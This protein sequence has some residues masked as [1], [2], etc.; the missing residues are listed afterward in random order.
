MAFVIKNFVILRILQYNRTSPRIKSFLLKRNG[1]LVYWCQ[2]N[3]EGLSYDV[4]FWPGHNQEPPEP[5]WRYKGY[6]LL[7]FNINCMFNKCSCKTS[8][9]LSKGC[10]ADFELRGKRNACFYISTRLRAVSYFSLQSYCTRNPSTRAA[11]NEG[12]SPRKKDKRLL[13]LLF[14]LGTTKL[15]T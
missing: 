9:Y 4:N 8:E 6:I 3:M 10:N 1:G 13:T 7:Q 11:I 12:V 5:S 15:S 14:C 2:Y